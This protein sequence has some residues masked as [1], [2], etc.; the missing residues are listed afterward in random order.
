M[1]K[2]TE[3][4]LNEL[5]EKLNKIYEERYEDNNDEEMTWDLENLVWKGNDYY[6]DEYRDRM[7]NDLELNDRNE[8]DIVTDII[9]AHIEAVQEEIWW[10]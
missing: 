8:M 7:G 2:Y 5:Y 1:K 6:L 3:E 4:E 10:V 9:K